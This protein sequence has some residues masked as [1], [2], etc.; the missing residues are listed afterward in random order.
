MAA[1]WESAPVVS[2]G[3][4]SAPTVDGAAAPVIDRNSPAYKQQEAA[5]RQEGAEARRR[6]LAE[7]GRARGGAWMGLTDPFEGA[8][9]LLEHG[10]AGVANFVAPNSAPARWLSENSR[11]NDLRRNAD[12]AAYDAARGPNAGMDF[13]RIAGNIANPANLAGGRLLVGANG[14][15]QL[16]VRGAGAGAIGGALQP[17]IGAD[18]QQ[19]FAGAKGLQTG[20]G[21]AGGALLTPAFAKAS[22]GLAKV[23]NA[24]GSRFVGAPDATIQTQAAKLVDDWL[25][26]TAATEGADMAQ[27]PASIR[28]NVQQQVFAALKAGRQVDPA[29]LARAA[30]FEAVGIAPT[31]GQVTRNPMQ[32][33]RERNLRGVEGAGEPLTERFTEQNNRLMQILGQRAAGALEP[34]DAG[35]ALMAALREADAPVRTAID[36]AYQGARAADGRYAAVNTPQFSNAANDALDSQMLGRFL[37][38]DA[39]A[40]LNDISDGTIPLTVNN[41]VQVDSVLAAA[42]R[43]NAQNPAAQKAI[44]VVRNA[45]NSADIEGSAGAQAKSAFDTARGMARTRFKAIEDTPGLQ[46]ALDNESPDAFVRKFLLGGDVKSVNNLMKVLGQDEGAQSLARAQVASHLRD[47]AFGTNAAGDAQFSQAGFNRA[48]QAI[49]RNKLVAIFGQDEADKLLQLGRVGAYIQA[50]PS[51]SAVNNSNTAGAVM[52]LLSGLS[53]RFGALPVINIARDSLRTYGNER[54]AAQ[55]LKGQVPQSRELPPE[56]T[57]NLM[58]YLAGPAAV[59]VGASAGALGQ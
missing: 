16:A 35:G 24:V 45:L 4:Q 34:D 49:G 17:V 22:T 50:Q 2:Q 9:Q 27:I 31:Q 29:A 47:K 6:A 42:Q 40:L 11:L 56:V 41:L 39:R 1:A 10:A 15:R 5:I 3:W 55:A 30:E 54:F 32:F 13:T 51:G 37:P 21:A 25:A 52:N 36:R 43:A 19:N 59:G 46:A 28:A 26:A 58:R 12:E 23:V 33:A 7:A 38:A 20:V 18:Q 44:G 57:N 53:G 14:V 8:A 48:L